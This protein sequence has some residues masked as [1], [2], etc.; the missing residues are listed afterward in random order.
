M[1]KL[2]ALCSTLLLAFTAHAAQFEEGKHYK[3]LDVDKASKPTVTEF[4]SFYCPHCYKFEAVIDNMK[5]ALPKGASFEKVHVAFMG[6]DMAVPMAKSYATMVSLGVEKKMV[7]A[8]FAQIHQKRQAPKDESELKQIFVDNGVDA[9][10]F[11]AAY[12]SFAV[13]SMQKGFDKQFKQSTLTGVPGVLVNDK[14]I[15]IPNEI[16]TYD[17]YNELVNYLLT[18]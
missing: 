3:V 8:M 6:S 18:L 12:N 4:F 13:N 17:E 10:K 9:K 11:D 14:Y 16:R 2:L 5:P 7:P 1:K 15:V